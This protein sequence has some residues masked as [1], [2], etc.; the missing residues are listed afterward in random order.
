MPSTRSSSRRPGRPGD[1]LEV[2]GVPGQA[3]RSGQILE[4][5]GRPDHPHYRVR[6]DEKHESIVYPTEG[7]SIV[8]APRRRPR[9]R[10]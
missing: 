9:R 4:V 3:A 1:W 7:A 2:K 8:R 10:P 5:L 6:W